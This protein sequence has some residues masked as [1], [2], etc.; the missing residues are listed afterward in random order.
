MKCVGFGEYEDICTN[1]AGTPWTPYWCA[2]CDEIRKESISKNFEDM[3]INI[4]KD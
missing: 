3:V 1:E 2:R 4:K